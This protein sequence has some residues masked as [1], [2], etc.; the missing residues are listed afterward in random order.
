M[1]SAI[2]GAGNA[3]RPRGEL[4]YW[5]STTLMIQECNKEFVQPIL[6]N[7]AVYSELNGDIAYELFLQG[8]VS[9]TKAAYNKIASWI[10]AAKSNPGPVKYA[11]ITIQS[12]KFND[13]A[14]RS[15]CSKSTWS[16]GSTKAT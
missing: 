9:S 16:E 15:L 7:P 14:A 12:Q 13:C 1:H 2:L 6:D 8:A 11:N 3:G 5:P 10:R 4:T